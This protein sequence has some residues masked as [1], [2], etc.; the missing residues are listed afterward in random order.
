MDI[1]DKFLD[2]Y[3]ELEH[4]SR[5]KYNL[6]EGKSFI[7]NIQNRPEFAGI[8]KELICCNKVRNLLA[9]EKR[10]G[11]KYV[12]TPSDEMFCLLDRAITIVKNPLFCKDIMICREKVCCKGLK[13]KISTTIKEMVE[14]DLTNIPILDNEK[15]IGAFSENTVFTC[16]YKDY[17]HKFDFNGCLG[18]IKNSL[19]LQNHLT[20]RFMFAAPNDLVSGLIPRIKTLASSEKRL[21]MIFITRNGDRNEQLLGIMT[22]WDI[23]GKANLTTDFI[24]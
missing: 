2:K 3:R 11:N 19:E 1:A 10:I 22:S 13:N 21:A 15:V 20:D 24:P 12:V 5:I 8:K 23:I 14:K 17:T 16:L 6:D 4:I 18:D 9:H 7:Y